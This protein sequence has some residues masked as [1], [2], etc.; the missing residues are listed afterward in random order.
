MCCDGWNYGVAVEE[1]P[2]CGE[3][4]DEDG[5]AV[6]GCNWAPVDCEVCGAAPCDGSC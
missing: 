3:P 2:A 1:C 6:E 5:D 4:I